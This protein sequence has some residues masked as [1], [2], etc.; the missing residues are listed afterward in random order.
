WK[1]SKRSMLNSPRFSYNLMG[2]GSTFPILSGGAKGN[3]NTTQK[4]LILHLG[5]H[6][7]ASLKCRFLSSR[8]VAF[9]GTMQRHSACWRTGIQA[10]RPIYHCALEVRMQTYSHR[11]RQLFFL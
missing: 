11:S 1:K 8:A 3:E 5:L 9:M 2:R 6:R 10:R 4:R 7:M